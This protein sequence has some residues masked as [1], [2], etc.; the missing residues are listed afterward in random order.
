MLFLGLVMIIPVFV[1]NIT[2]IRIIESREDAKEITP[3]VSLI[4]Q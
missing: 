3:T 4:Y 2:V 1:L